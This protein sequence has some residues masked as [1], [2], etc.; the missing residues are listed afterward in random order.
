MATPFEM[1]RDLGTIFGFKPARMG[2]K[3]L[4]YQL[5]A[6]LVTVLFERT[7]VS[8]RGRRESTRSSTVLRTYVPGDGRWRV[9]AQA[10]SLD[11]GADCLDFTAPTA[12]DQAESAQWRAL[13]R[14][15]DRDGY[16]TPV[17][18]SR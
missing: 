2:E 17:S 4:R 12:Q 13:G 14:P 5:H 9:D 7:T 18:P 1:N 11:I 3:V 10:T 16:R 8:K 15:Y 6:G